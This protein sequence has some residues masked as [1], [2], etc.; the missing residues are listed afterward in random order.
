MIAHLI[1]VT[2][3]ASSRA[4]K[5]APARMLQRKCACGTRTPAG[6]ECEACGKKKLNLQR[7]AL[8]RRGEPDEIP[9][10]VH[11][12][13]RS[14][15]QPLD[16]PTRAFMEPRFGHD[17]SHVRVHADAKAAESAQAVNALAYTA[18]RAVVFGPGQYVPETN[19][20]RRLLAHELAHVMQQGGNAWALQQ[21]SK[22]GEE[23]D[24]YEQEAERS[25]AQC[26]KGAQVQ[27]PSLVSS[28]LIQRTKVCSK[29]LDNPLGRLGINHS[30]IDDTG[31]NNCLGKSML[32]N[33]AIQTLV[34]GNFLK[35]CAIKTAT[36]TDPQ[37]YTPN[38]KQ[39]D[40][41]PG[42]ID[43]SKCMRD[44]YN[45][46]VDP[47]LYKNPSGPNSNTF[48]ATL[49]KNCCAD[50]SSKGLGRVPGWD[51]SPAPP[52]PQ[53]PKVLV[54]GGAREDQVECVK[55]LGLCAIP[56]GIPTDDDIRRWNE[57]CRRRTRYGG[58]DVSRDDCP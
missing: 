8:D 47:S 27:V 46:Y 6:G 14:S 19:D 44:T 23:N 13:L 17:L 45:S 9:S 30:Y 22:L 20:G 38:V 18:G 33:Y 56:G 7:R 11:E 15:G 31:S 41:K 49:A 16:A 21:D 57:E 2:S 55:D 32:G 12:V 39:C 4:L 43:L 10:I 48:A 28:T 1:S 52:C 37:G 25:A 54:A 5:Q 40:P 34:S 29:R 36:S 35:G 26:M 3:G 24:R 53:Q 50:G 42:V 58:D 51:D